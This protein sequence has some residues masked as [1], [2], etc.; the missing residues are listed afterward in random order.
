MREVFRN[1]CFK[2][3]ADLANAVGALLTPLV[4]EHVIDTGKPIGVVDGNQPG[5]GKTLLSRCMAAVLDGCE[6]DMI[7]YTP[8]NEEME[9]R[10]CSTIRSRRSSILLIDNAKR[11]GGGEISSPAIEANACA[12]EFN[13]R[14]L[15]TSR[16]FRGRNIMFWLITMNDAK[17]GPD[18]VSRCLPIQ[19][20][21]EGSA[22]KRAFDGPEPFEFALGHRPELLAELYGIVLY[23]LQHR[24]LLGGQAHRFPHWAATIGGILAT[25]GIDG[26][27]ENFAVVSTTLNS[28]LDQ[29]SALAETAVADSRGPWLVPGQD[30]VRER[31]RLARDWEPLLKQAKVDLPA[32]ANARSK[33]AR[34]TLIGGYL[35]RF[36]GRSVPIEAGG[37]LGT[38]CL[39]DVP[40]RSNQRGYYFEV[41]WSASDIPD[42][43]L[44]SPSLPADNVHYDPRP[45]RGRGDLVPRVQQ[46]GAGITFP[47][48]SPDKQSTPSV[49]SSTNSGGNVENW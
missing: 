19:L 18:L 36:L 39:R 22:E 32:L 7:A 13:F 17:L 41:T 20:N 14:I 40:L 46:S 21:Y 8:D 48:D 12:P 37:R 5:I 16:A 3:P 1:F 11:P 49:P 34:A 2:T 27:L 30:S 24:R 10:L 44:E 43:D 26:F 42:C 45:T 4:I 47:A 9:K 28:T 23:W 31:S 6:T 38:A 33:R 25:F 29:L 35:R 15:G